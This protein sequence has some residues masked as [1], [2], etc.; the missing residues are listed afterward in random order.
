MSIITISRR[1]FSRGK[2]VA[3][4]VARKLGYGCVAREVLFEAAK[5]F[6]IQDSEM[7]RA[8]H[9]A[10]SFSD[11]FHYGRE[12]YVAFFQA[13]LLDVLQRDNIVYHGLAGHFFVQDVPHALKVRVITSLDERVRILTDRENISARNAA[14]LIKREDQDR[15]KWSQHL[16]GID[17][18]DA[19]LYNLVLNIKDISVDDA[20]E[21]I[22]HAVRL[23]C[24]RTTPES[25]RR[26]DD[27]VIG[28][29]VKAAMIQ[30][31]PDIVATV[32]NG[33]VLVKTHARES[34]EAELCRE[35]EKIAKAIPGVEEI[36]IQVDHSVRHYD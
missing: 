10:P 20:A 27:L 29:H 6:D 5:R 25:Q 7:I 16:Y 8:I 14:R 11:H 33:R 13:A 31:K 23:D 36:K 15:R 30:T 35:I 24:F 34:E 19:S 2:E 17:T 18:W 26:I 4:Q 32:E 3:E 1:P 28:A 12:R 9:D 22:C 21:M